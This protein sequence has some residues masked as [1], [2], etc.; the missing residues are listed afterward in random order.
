MNTFTLELIEKAK[1]AK[2]AEELLALAKENEVEMTEESAA[3]YFAQLHPT[4]GEVS[5]DE[6]DNVSGGGCKTK[7]NG[8][9]YTVVT[10]NLSCFNGQWERLC[11]L[12]TN[13]NWGI[14]SG[15]PDFMLHATWN[16]M[17]G[18]RQCGSCKHLKF[19]AGTGY[20]SKS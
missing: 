5:E 12:C 17:A 19:K 4:S 3:A 11:V 8:E 14:P 13:G 16:A 7:V 10:S 18:D 6:L 1:A 2:T 9:S 20:C 15:T